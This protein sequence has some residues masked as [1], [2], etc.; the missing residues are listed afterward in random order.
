M[1]QKVWMQFKFAGKLIEQQEDCTH[2]Y[3]VQFPTKKSFGGF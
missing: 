3:H 2:P 1:S